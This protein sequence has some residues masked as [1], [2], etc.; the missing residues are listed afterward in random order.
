VIGSTNFPFNGLL[1]SIRTSF[2]DFSVP[3]S[4]PLKSKIGLKITRT[5]TVVQIPSDADSED[6]SQFREEL[7]D[8]FGSYDGG[9]MVG[10]QDLNRTK[11]DRGLESKLVDSGIE[12]ADEKT[13]VGMEE[14]VRQ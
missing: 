11:F 5:K 4:S 13:I 10:P 9:S 8:S 6:V 12:W 2:R 1:D 14:V 3:F 7:G